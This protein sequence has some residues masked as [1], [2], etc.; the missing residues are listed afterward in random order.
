MKLLLFLLL[1]AALSCPVKAQWPYIP[2]VQSN[3]AS[4]L[5]VSAANNVTSGNIA[6]AG[7]EWFGSSGACTATD[8]RSST[9]TEVLNRFDSTNGIGVCILITTYGSSGS[10]T[11]TVAQSGSSFTQ[12]SLTELPPN[13]ST[14][15]DTSTSSLWSGTPATVTSASFT[16]AAN[17]DF[18]YAFIGGFRNAGLFGPNTGMT[19]LGASNGSDS[20][21][22]AFKIAGT[23][24][25]YT[26][27]FTNATNDLGVIGVIAL[28]P[29]AL[30]VTS[31]ATAPDG[32][33]SNAY[34]YTLLAAGGTGSY[35]WSITSGSLQSGLSL[36]TSTGQISGTPTGSSTNSITFQVTDGASSTASKT[37]SLKV[38][39]SANSISAVQVL[40]GG[41]ANTSLAFA[42]N[43]TS[44]NLVLA[45]N[46]GAPGGLS[47]LARAC[48]DTLGTPLKP[49]AYTTWI[50]AAGNTHGL[51]LS[52]GIAPSG[53][54]DTV[55]CG[56]LYAIGEFSGVM[57]AGPG[58]NGVTTGNNSGAV[59]ITSSTLTTL[60]PNEVVVA[61]CGTVSDVTTTITVDSPLTAIGSGS[62]MASGYDV[63]ST[64]TGYTFSCDKPATTAGAKSD[65]AIVLNGFRPSAGAV[66]NTPG[67]PWIIIVNGIPA[68][69][70]R[71]SPFWRRRRR[72]L[73]EGLEV[74]I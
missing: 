22:T 62:G 53:G 72:E 35:T 61:L 67:Q 8:T 46:Y 57:F 23:N 9:W 1:L 4:G 51:E 39:A 55:T 6:I 12:S 20:A 48:T 43:V 7:A 41:G 5:V 73:V 70:W 18:V 2:V 47:G 60:V 15:I 34:D 64:V 31:E 13:W 59:T 11:V 42:S 56:N 52:A 38:G 69:S 30:I 65:W 24:G 40:S 17:Y 44:G 50:T 26:A 71:V 66:S 27:S 10:N 19:G 29:S 74:D 37:I 36:N 63:V 45:V 32:A 25:S 14:T 3:S 33:L 16:T 49:I 28:K 68:L 58:S 54:A 21:G